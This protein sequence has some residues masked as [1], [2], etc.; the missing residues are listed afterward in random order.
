MIKNRK[1]AKNIIDVVED[2]KWV[3]KADACI[4]GF[5]P[6]QRQITAK[7]KSLVKELIAKD[8][9]TRFKENCTALGLVLPLQFQFTGYTGTTNRKIKIANS[10]VISVDLSQVLSEGEQTVAALADFLTE[11]ELNGSYGGVVFDDPVTSMDHIRKELIAQRLVDEAARRQVIVFTHDILFTDYLAT[12]AKEKGVP[13]TARTVYRDDTHAPGTVD[14]LAFPHLH[15]ED[16]AR[17]RAKK[18]LDTAQT[19][20][21]DAQHDMLEK[22]CG[23]LRTAYE[24]FIQK[25]LFN[26]VVR[27]WR[28]NITFTLNQVFFSED[29]AARVHE[30]MTVLSRYIDAHSHS[31]EFHQVPLTLDVVTSELTQFDTIKSD[32][33]TARKNWEKSKPKSVFD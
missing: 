1:P 14:W 15:Y 5:A 13:F 9:I 16:A 18:Y 26:N 7:Q 21:G 11:I 31:N 4:S 6:I 28:E 22:A 2:L 12:A 8:F 23:R 20:A 25:K 10:E 33:S 27:R 30:R 24:D 19:L 32:Y 29:I 17:E 3:K